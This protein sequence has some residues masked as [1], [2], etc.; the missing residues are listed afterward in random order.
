MNAILIRALEQAKLEYF[1]Q[2]DAR[3]RTDWRTHTHYKLGRAAARAMHSIVW[4][5]AR[6]ARNGAP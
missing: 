2:S 5:E 6:L 1:I 3:S 4:I